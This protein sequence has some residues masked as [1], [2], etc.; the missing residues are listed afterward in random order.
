MT[1]SP[2]I[3]T[4]RAILKAIRASLGLVNSSSELFTFSQL[5]AVRRVLRDALVI[6]DSKIQAFE[7]GSF[8]VN[9]L[10]GSVTNPYL[11][12][13]QKVVIDISD[14]ELT[15]DEDEM[16]DIDAPG[17]ES[18]CST[19]FRPVSHKSQLPRKGVMTVC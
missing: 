2:S 3:L 12:G 14:W 1:D 16:S 8:A 13:D 5:L 19:N 9:V 4:G 15:S 7:S 6:I 10:E 18:F 11:S 17:R